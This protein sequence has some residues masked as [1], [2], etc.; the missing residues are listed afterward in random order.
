[1]SINAKDRKAADEGNLDARLSYLLC[2]SFVSLTDIV[3]FHSAPAGLGS[4]S[5]A[6]ECVQLAAAFLPASSLAGRL[7]CRASER[8]KKA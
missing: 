7:E 3:E 5:E 1:M 6:L 2:D 4:R 8:A